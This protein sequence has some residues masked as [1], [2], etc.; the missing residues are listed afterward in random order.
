MSEHPHKVAI[1]VGR[2]FEAS[3]S[4]WGLSILAGALCVLVVA[5]LGRAVGLW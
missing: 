5:L 3:A 1:R 2:W 4:G